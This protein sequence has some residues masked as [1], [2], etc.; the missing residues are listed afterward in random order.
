MSGRRLI[1]QRY[2]LHQ[3]PRVNR[4]TDGYARKKEGW[5]NKCRSFLVSV[6]V[7]I[8]FP[9][10][11]TWSR[12]LLQCR[13]P[14]FDPWVRKIPWRREQLPTPGFWPGIFHGL[15]SPWGHKELGTTKQLSRHLLSQLILTKLKDINLIDSINN[16]IPMIPY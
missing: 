14:G 3:C 1:R 11:L 5:K 8:G 12:I 6:Q 7:S 4:G 9:W 15:Y 16:V 2:F 13:R 10:W